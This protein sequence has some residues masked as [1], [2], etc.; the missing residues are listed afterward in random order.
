M[1]RGKF[2]AKINFLTVAIGRAILRIKE[3]HGLNP[4]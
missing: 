2:T 3:L 4:E 1:I